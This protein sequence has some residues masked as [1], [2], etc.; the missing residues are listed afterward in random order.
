MPRSSYKPR[1]APR[2]AA[3]HITLTAET[4]G[5]LAVLASAQ[6]PVVFLTG[7][8][9]TGK[10]TLLRYYRAT[11]AKKSVV[12]APTG[13]AAV[14]V[15]GQ[16]IHSFFRFGPDI[17]VA[18]V[19]SRN[20]RESV[21]FKRLQEIIIDEISMVRAD[22]LDCIDAFLR[23][24]GAVPDQPFGGVRMIF[25]GDLYQL[26]PVV[27]PEEAQL[28]RTYY[29]SPYF[30]DAR[31]FQTCPLR[32]VELTTVFRQR[33]PDFVAIL[34][35]I[36][37]SSMTATQLARVNTRVRQSP[38]PPNPDALVHLVPTNAQAERINAAHL[39]RLSP[40]AVVFQQVR[41]E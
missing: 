26:P 27:P 36:R 15:Q 40:P 17:T 4:Q 29:A 8:A 41:T 12:L 11:T 10:S 6:D 9:G 33:D 13:V 32:R 38:L 3:P 20:D 21:L 22:L 24:N 23:L 1:S 5:A 37:T 31:V 35:A 16:T 39:A 30:F 18:K 2:L 7:R 25:V 34:D 19:R 28:F 14:H